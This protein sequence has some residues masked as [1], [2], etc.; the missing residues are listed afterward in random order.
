V[1]LGG[2]WAG[3]WDNP[4]GADHGWMYDDGPGWG[5]RDNI[6]GKLATASSCGGTRHEVA[7][8]AGHVTKGK[9]YGN[10]ETGLFAGVCGPT[11][12]DVVLTW[13]KA[14]KLLHIKA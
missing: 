8:G 11:P 12:T 1:S 2:N 4:M 10:S 5:H 13:A 6:L 3:G 14:K 7:M 9:T